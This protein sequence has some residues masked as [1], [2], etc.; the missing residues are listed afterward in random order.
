[1]VLLIGTPAGGTFTGPGLFNSNDNWYF[2]PRYAPVGTHEIVYSYKD[3][4]TQC[5]G[6][7]TAVVRVLE[8]NA[9]IE[10]PENR[11]KYCRNEDPFTVTGVNLADNIGSFIITGGLGL[12][13]HGDNTATV[14]PS[15][16]S[17]KE[18]TITYTYFDGTTLN[19]TSTFEVRQPSCG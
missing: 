15:L 2:L 5:Y 3:G 19:V 8:A 17:V 16:L 7:D 18:Y 13:D 9:I 12:V 14:D 6:Y 11:V 10:F 1:M 4:T